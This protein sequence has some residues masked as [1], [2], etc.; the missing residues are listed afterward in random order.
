MRTSDTRD[1][2]RLICGR[3]N[4]STGV[5]HPVPAGHT[6]RRVADDTPPTG[7]GSLASIPNTDWATQ[8][9]VRHHTT[10]Y[11]AAR[12]ADALPGDHRFLGKTRD[13]STGYTLVGARWYDEGLGRF[14]SVDPVMDLTD[15]QQW[16]GYAYAGNSPVTFSDP[17]G[18]IRGGKDLT[19]P[20]GGEVT[21]TVEG[22]GTIV[23]P[24]PTVQGPPP[25]GPPPTTT[26]TVEPSFFTEFTRGLIDYGAE[27]VQGAIQLAQTEW[28]YLKQCASS[29]FGSGC[30]A[31]FDFNKQLFADALNPW[32]AIQGLIDEFN[33]LKELFDSGRTAYALG[34]LSAIVVETLVSK[35]GGKAAAL[36]IKSALKNSGG[37]S[38]SSSGGASCPWKSFGA[39]T[40][41]L[42]A[43]GTHKAIADIEPGDEVIATD[44]ETGEQAAREVTHVWVHQD[45]LY[46]F[47]VNGELIVTTED[48]PFWSVTDQAWEDTQ[49]LH[50]GERVLT[51]TGRTATRAGRFVFV[52]LSDQG[53]RSFRA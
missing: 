22:A 12:S 29:A 36:A 46:D 41:V 34:R 32:N 51:A 7:K 19:L 30:R 31:F 47:E 10:P 39:A 17:S 40:L 13:A 48:H 26:T 27:M 11:G 42:M 37:S 3:N 21:L 45:D 53:E 44:P 2:G 28:T 16:H 18:L 38:G 14:L 1:S 49:D 20:V 33:N 6:T 5:P 15:P 52:L 35:G 43:D 25:A 50:Q 24:A 4:R 23:G 9:V 8:K